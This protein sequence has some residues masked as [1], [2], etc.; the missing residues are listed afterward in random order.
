MAGWFFEKIYQSDGTELSTAGMSTSLAGASYA[1]H[2]GRYIW[3]TCGT[4]GVYVFEYWGKKS[5]DEPLFEDLDELTLPRYDSGIKQKPR[6]ICAMKIE[7]GAYRR[8]T[9]EASLADSG[10]TSYSIGTEG[11]IAYYK[12]TAR[13]GNALNAL[14]IA[15]LGTKMYVASGSQFQELYE[16]DIATMQFTGTVLNVAE[17]FNGA[18]RGMNS[19]L[20]QSGGRLWM[21][22]GYSVLEAQDT[23][24]QKL[25]AVNS[26]GVK[27][28]YDLNSR[29]GLARA[30]LSDGYNGYVYC[31]L[32]NDVGVR[33]IDN[34]TGSNSYIR[35]NAF[36]TRIWSGPD[37]RIWASSYAGMLSLIDWDDDQVH[38]N[39]GTEGEDSESG[40]LC[41]LVDLTDGT[42]FWVISSDNKLIRVNLNDSTWF[43][44]GVSGADT[45]VDVPVANLS[46]LKFSA[47]SLPNTDGIKNPSEYETT[48]T[49]KK[50]VDAASLV[51]VPGKDWEFQSPRLQTPEF[52]IQTPAMTYQD[53]GG[54]SVEVKPYIWFIDSGKLRGFRL[55]NYLYRKAY[56]NLR[57][58]AAVSSGPEFYFGE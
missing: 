47:T 20:C 38:S 17:T 41:G 48:L 18:P 14:F 30:W 9:R 39:W 53:A 26:S 4:G 55:H 25:Y 37:R 57:G 35:L 21:V 33:K 6:L 7:S 52:L 34:L 24:R 32:P 50:E 19:N 16:F 45:E 46:E 8:V 56:G 43:E 29:P 27:S 12:S 44:Q 2:D 5:D 23:V 42:K 28:T 11:E 3:V 10:A 1:E 31:T 40:S 13:S 51:T 58:Q 15:K 54:A 22:G 49:I 36:P